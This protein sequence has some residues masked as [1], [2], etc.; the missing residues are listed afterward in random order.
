MRA[1]GAPVT[2]SSPPMWKCICA[3]CSGSGHLGG[4][5]SATRC[6]PTMGR[7]PSS[8]VMTPPVRRILD[9]NRHVEQPV[10]ESR[11]DLGIR[12]V[13]HH[14][15]QP[16]HPARGRDEAGVQAEGLPGRILVHP[17]SAA[18]DELRRARTE[19]RLFGL[20]QVRHL[21]LQVHLRGGSDLSSVGPV[22]ALAEAQRTADEGAV[23]GS[24]RIAL[25]VALVPGQRGGPPSSGA[26]DDREPQSLSLSSIPMP[27]TL[28]ASSNTAS[29]VEE[30]PDQ[31][32]VDRASAGHP[33]N[34]TG[35]LLDSG[36]HLRAIHSSES[37]SGI[38]TPP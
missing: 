7:S 2:G 11:Q 12:T 18:V 35:Q 16:P 22:R 10:P 32:V 15:Q 37:R 31:A 25:P 20:L 38:V 24:E 27:D 5:W 26:D 3:G 17:P 34:G 6:R 4:R 23:E 1:R 19:H 33:A 28:P 9:P 36:R 21:H 29:S 14:P 13:D 8:S 30:H